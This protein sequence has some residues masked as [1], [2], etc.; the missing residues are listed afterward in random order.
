[1]PGTSLHGR[2]NAVDVALV[3][4]LTEDGRARDLTHA[5][6]STA[7]CFDDPALAATLAESFYSADP[8]FNRLQ[9]EIWHFEYGTAGRDTRGKHTA[10]PQHCKKMLE[11][12]RKKKGG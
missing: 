2:G 5:A 4:K 7:Q 3:E 9:S 1:V 6:G 8:D 11:K 10:M 12:K